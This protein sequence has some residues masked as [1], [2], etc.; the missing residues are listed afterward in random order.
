MSCD[1]H[2]TAIVDPAAELGA[3]VQIGPYSIIGPHVKLGDRCWVGPH[4]VVEGRTTIG[5]ESKVFQFASVGAKPQDLKFNDEPSTLVIGQK[6]II[7]EFVTLQPGTEH[8]HMTTVIGDGNLFM[9]NSH[10]GHDCRVGNYNVFANSVALAGHVTIDNNVILGGIVGIHQF[11]RIGSFVMLSGG[12][13]VG[14]DI[15]PYCIGQGDRCF[16]R[17]VNTI[18]L[19]R[20]GFTDEEISAV[21]KTY[22]LLFSSVG[23]LAEKIAGLPEELRSMD[24]IAHM[25]EFIKNSERGVCSPAR[26]KG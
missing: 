21:K 3:E 17:G 1:I 5:A 16:L 24:K 15:P 25:L 23:G 4:A 22:R 20:A 12:S 14:H 11:V 7:R 26:N 18:G 13:M 9:A 8:G 10:V 19:Q 6:N 2:E